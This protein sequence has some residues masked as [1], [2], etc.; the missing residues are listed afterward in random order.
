MGT[1][2]LE[3]RVVRER[4]V[5]RVAHREVDGR[6]EQIVLEDDEP[7]AAARRQHTIAARVSETVKRRTR[8]R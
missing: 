4:G 2:N 6:L 3:G 5:E 7:V 1:T 8:Y